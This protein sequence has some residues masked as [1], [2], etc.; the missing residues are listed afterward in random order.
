MISYRLGSKRVNYKVKLNFVSRIEERMHRRK[1]DE[2]LR[3]RSLK[4]HWRMCANQRVSLDTI[5][6]TADNDSLKNKTT[7][8]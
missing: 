3:N 4:T 2:E 7:E 8:C 1:S 5:R 6:T